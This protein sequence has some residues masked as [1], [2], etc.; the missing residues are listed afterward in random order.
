MTSQIVYDD[1]MLCR[2]VEQE[3]CFTAYTTVYK[4]AKV[5]GEEKF[6]LLIQTL[7]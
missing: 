6:K 2:H 1:E 4:R 5:K 3:S 7:I